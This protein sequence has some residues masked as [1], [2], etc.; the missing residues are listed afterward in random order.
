MTEK[1]YISIDGEKQEA[2]GEVLAQILKDR[3]EYEALELA[4]QQEKESKISA[5]NSAFAK[6]AALGLT[7]DEIDAL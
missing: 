5:R 7:Q 2:Q 6:L 4:S 3:A 1:I